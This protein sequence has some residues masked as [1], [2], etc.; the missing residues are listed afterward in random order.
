MLDLLVLVRKDV[1]QADHLFPRD[2][3]NGRR[4]CRRDPAR[5]FAEIDE[6]LLCRQAANPVTDKLR[7]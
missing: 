7:Q 1:S 6:Q 3:G 4:L 5:R 2:T